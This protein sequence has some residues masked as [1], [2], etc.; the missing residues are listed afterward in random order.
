M[1]LWFAIYL[2]EV[3]FSTT[4]Q[5]KLS[6]FWIYHNSCCFHVSYTFSPFLHMSVVVFFF[7]HL[8]LNV[9]IVFDFAFCNL[10]QIFATCTS[11]IPWKWHSSRCIWKPSSRLWILWNNQYL[12]KKSFQEVGLPLLLSFSLFLL[13]LSFLPGNIILCCLASLICILPHIK[14]MHNARCT[15]ASAYY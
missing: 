10:L 8:R 2:Q 14:V 6:R 5:F 9:K 12:C 11:W 7:L 15:W 4:Y 3:Y 13:G 1:F